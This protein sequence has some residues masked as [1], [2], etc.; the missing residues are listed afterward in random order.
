MKLDFKFQFSELST[1]DLNIDAI[2]KGGNRGNQSDDIF[3]KLL[4][5]ENSGGFRS[6]NS[7]TEP[8]LLAL[9]SSI[10]VPEWP[11]FLDIETGIFTY[12]GDN[13]TPGHTILDTAKKGNQ[14]LE[15]LFKWTH[16][17]SE[18]RKKVPPIFIFTKEGTKGRDY[19]FRGLAVPGNPLFAQT[20]D[21]VAVWKTKN[22]LRFQNYKA[23]FSVLSIDIIKR[24]WISDIHKGK[25]FGKNCPDVW[26]QWIETGKYKILTSPKEKKIRSKEDQMPQ[27]QKGKALLEIVYKY[28]SEI[29][30]HFDFENFAGKIFQMSDTKHVQDFIVTRSSRDGGRDVIG[31]YKIGT[32]QSSYQFS[33]ALEAKRFKPDGKH[34]IGV[35]FTNRLISR[36]KYREFGVFVT[37]SYID[38]QA[39]EEIIEDNHPIIFITGKDIVDILIKSGIDEN[40]KLVDFLNKN[41]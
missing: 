20:E 17:G 41:F 23:T 31:D 6:L 34:G 5:L 4:G 13:R 25:V 22:N 30:D 19:R 26:R 9:I 18:N 29:K 35:R 39:Y 27:D 7:R 37:T 21:L 33:Y 8:T 36:I 11:D 32:N 2:Y 16:S 24:D 15:N 3:N 40:K 12:Y 28:F 10:D 38:K 14:C 1:A